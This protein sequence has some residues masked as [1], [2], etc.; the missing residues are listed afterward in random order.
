MNKLNSSVNWRVTNT[1][2]PGGGVE[3]WK[4]HP[5]LVLSIH[6]KQNLDLRQKLQNSN[7]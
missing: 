7:K 4:I 6:H 3:G 1:A 5:T 2:T